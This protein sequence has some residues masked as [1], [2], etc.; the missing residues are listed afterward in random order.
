MSPEH[1]MVKCDVYCDW[2]DQPPVYRLFVGNELFVERT[3]IWQTQY[4]EESIPVCARPGKYKIRYELVEPSQAKLQ[5]KN[6][7]V[8][9]G[10]PG[11]RIM[12]N[13]LLRI[14]PHEST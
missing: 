2:Q 10:P 5:I 13:T 6:L 7:R 9:S 8:D 14:Y 11:A 3:Y 12:K 1:V 4:L